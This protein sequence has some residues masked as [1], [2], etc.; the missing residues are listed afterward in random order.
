MRLRIFTAALALVIAAPALSPAAAEAERER[1]TTTHA[2][3]GS[4]V[5]PEGVAFDQRT[6]FIYVG[7]KQDGTI[8]RGQARQ[9]ALEVFLPGGQDGR[10]T[11]TGL[12]VD[13]FGRLYVAGA[14]SGQIF[15]Y[16]TRSR[17]LIRRFDTGL[18]TNVFLNDLTFDRRGNAYFTDSLSPV[19]WRVP[20]AAV[21]SGAGPGTPERFLDFTG[22]AVQFQPGFNLNG[23]STPDGRRL[24]TVQSN[25]GKI[26]R[27][28]VDSRQ[29]AEVPVQGGPLTAGDGLVS[30][31]RRL[32]VVRN[33][34]QVVVTVALD[35]QLA[36]G[37][38]VNQ[39]TDPLFRFP[40]TAALGRDR[41]LVANSQFDKQATGNPE[42]PFTVADVPIE[43]VLDR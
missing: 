10:V 37:S 9:S 23:I 26:F 15:V 20:E 13:R 35:R 17:A 33:Q 27:I 22:T 32:L 24:L 36:S 43:N 21:R 16:D 40:T 8:F 12:K 42:L 18:R 5:F 6:G 14:E 34:F 11:A 41:L 19:L 7:S 28:D 30:L 2:I 31:G 1:Q 3:P 39:Y 29:V 25:T 4:A 38:V